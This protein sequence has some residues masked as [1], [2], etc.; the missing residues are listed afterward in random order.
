MT[1][2]RPLRAALL[3][4]GVAG[5]AFHAPFLATTEG[6]E[7][8]TVVTRSPD[9]AAAAQQRYPGVR[10]VPTA[11]EVWRAADA[12][13]LVVVAT[14]NSTHVPLAL[15]AVAA[16]LPVVVDKPVAPTAADARRLGDV[17]AAAGVPLAVYQNRRWDG[18]ARTVRGLLAQGALGRVHRFESRF[19]RWRP[20]VRTDSWREGA[21][22]A[23]AGG[24]L[25]DLGSHLVDQ[26]LW[27]FGPVSGV[28]AELAA[29]RPGA[30]VEDDVFVALEH[31]NGTR[32]HLWA[33]ALAAAPGPRFRVLG[34]TA[35]YVKHGMDA[36]EAALRDGAVPGG[37]GWGTEP[38]SSWGTLGVPGDARAVP[39]E[40]GA[41]QD[42]YVAMR[43]AVL[44]R[45]PV[46]VPIDDAIAGLA[47]LEAARASAREGRTVRW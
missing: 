34:S 11:D 13:D 16:G 20:Q 25:L 36:Q 28:Y 9:R 12:H 1:A 2:A 29:L 38:P 24:L 31:A 19:E 30:V 45:G 17:A 33:S 47:V 41:Y 39:T 8:A 32:S 18:D 5:S 46:P 7:L 43:D 22:P 15:E 10:V 27:L 35:A 40:P 4:Y 21:D 6:I 26:A 3:G 23:E 14:P 44:G 37:P 42:F